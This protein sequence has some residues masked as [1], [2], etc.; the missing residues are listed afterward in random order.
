MPTGVP[1]LVKHTRKA[2]YEGFL[3]KVKMEKSEFISLV[4]RLASINAV[5]GSESPAAEFC[6][7]ELRKYTDD[8]YIKA[9]NVIANIGERKPDKL[10][11]LLDAHIDRVGMIVCAV[12]GGF[13]KVSQVGGL[14]RRILPAQRVIIHGRNGDVCGTVC[15]LPP[16]LAKEK[17]VMEPDELW[18]DTGLAD[19]ADRITQGDP[20][21]FD[22]PCEEILGGRI[23]GAGLDDRAGAAVM[24][25]VAEKLSQES[26]LPCSVTVML[27]TQEEVT[28]R[29]ARVGAYHIDPDIA[30]EVDVSFA[31]CGGEKPEKCGKLG[32]GAMIGISPTLDR[33]L[34]DRLMG[35]AQELSLP[36]QTEVMHGTTGTNADYFTISRSGVRTAYAAIPLRYMHTP[37]EIVDISDLM[38]ITEL[39]AAFAGRCGT[40]E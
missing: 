30:L 39:A 5:S 32:G 33:A 13:A 31:L 17:K 26:E 34:S 8:V 2:T 36:Y 10:H 35:I 21:S 12:D 22:S 25:A 14:D 6:A 38:N 15:T 24:I 3:R 29:G 19:A 28:C 23:C 9:G 37:A 1:G 16:H 20:V 4:C 7:A 11:L 18:V 40:D 27:S